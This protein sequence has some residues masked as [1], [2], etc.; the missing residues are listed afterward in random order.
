V[1]VNGG[2]V[3][4]LPGFLRKLI[5]LPVVEKSFRNLMRSMAYSDKALAKAFPDPSDNRR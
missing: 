2:Y 1:L 4:A 5:S 3:P